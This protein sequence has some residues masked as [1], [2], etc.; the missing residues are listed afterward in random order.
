MNRIEGFGR[1]NLTT[2]FGSFLEDNKGD[3]KRE[4]TGFECSVINQCANLQ[5]NKFPPA[6]SLDESKVVYLTSQ[7]SD[8]FKDLFII[9]STPLGLKKRARVTTVSAN[10]SELLGPA[11]KK[12]SFENRLNYTPRFN[13]SKDLARYAAK[14]ELHES[15]QK[16]DPTI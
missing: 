10:E 14:R 4:L 11:Q 15:N 7:T 2:S 8:D 13:T 3:S 6:D 16:V 12:T 9:S 5:K 1:E